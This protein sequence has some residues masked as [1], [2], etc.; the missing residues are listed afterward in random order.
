MFTVFNSILLC[1]HNEL[2][3]SMFCHWHTVNYS[4]SQRAHIPCVYA[5]LKYLDVFRNFTP[6]YTKI[7]CWKLF[8]SQHTNDILHDVIYLENGENGRG[9]LK[10]ERV[11]N[12]RHLPNLLHDFSEQCL[13]KS[14][15]SIEFDCFCL[16]D[17][18]M[19]DDDEYVRWI[20][21]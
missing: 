14:G 5:R 8:N 10:R 18:A 15:N 4:V 17:L 7:S 11:R 13:P 2:E 12:F 1:V 19:I 20:L 16:A 3:C 9:S 6:F 21:M